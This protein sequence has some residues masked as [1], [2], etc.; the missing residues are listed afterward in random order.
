MERDNGPLAGLPFDIAK[1]RYRKPD[2]RNPF[3]PYELPT[4][5]GES[6]WDL[7]GR[8]TRALQ[9]VVRRRR[10]STLGWRMAISSAP[11]CT[12]F[13]ACHRDYVAAACDSRSAMPASFVPPTIPTNTS[14]LTGR[15]PPS[16]TKKLS[17]SHRPKWSTNASPYWPN[18][19]S[20]LTLRILHHAQ[21]N[22][23][24]SSLLHIPHPAA[25]LLVGLSPMRRIVV[26]I[27]SA[28]TDMAVSICAN[29]GLPLSPTTINQNTSAALM[30]KD[31]DSQG[32]RMGWVQ[33]F[34]P[35]ELLTTARTYFSCPLGSYE[36]S[37]PVDSCKTL[38]PC[39][40]KAVV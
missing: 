1:E 19:A 8:G 6:G 32:M 25:C 22:G 15:C 10:P 35:E 11:P 20:P 27:G 17:Y 37:G 13:W 34:V 36:A 30:T 33:A 14:G 31:A 2:S 12:A 18:S 26:F 3:E 4:G 9:S 40:T 38:P 28:H 24:V 39:P 7:F 21:R 23:I 29:L 5:N 16:W